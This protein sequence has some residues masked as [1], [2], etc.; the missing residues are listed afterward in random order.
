MNYS[1]V[2]P[3]VIGPPSPAATLP[4]PRAGGRSGRR[5]AASGDTRG[6]ILDA[7]RALF[8]THGLR[9]TTT[10]QIAQRAGVD[11][12]LLHHFFGT[13]AD[14]FEAAI[15]LPAVV[16]AIATE[17]RRPGDEVA[18]RIARLYLDRLFTEEIETFSAV[19]RTAVGNSD[20]IPAVQAAMQELL[21][22]VT[23]ALAPQGASP[24]ALQLIGAQFIGILVL[25]H[26]VGVGP[27]AVAP[28]DDLVRLLA[29]AFRTLIGA[30]TGTVTTSRVV[31]E[32][33]TR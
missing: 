21:R 33:R 27:I 8:A 31:G 19:L 12:A 16:D 24:L 6:A 14:L 25:R 9:G 13:K 22:R 3:P 30:S 20:D 29:P 17:L 5:P 10:R 15:H 2:V 1:P 18:E 32:E 11:V 26:L 7:A 23:E 4:A 28:S